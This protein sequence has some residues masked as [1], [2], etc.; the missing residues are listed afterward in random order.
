ML[1][2]FIRRLH[3]HEYQSKELMAKYGVMT[4]RFRVI[5]NAEETMNQLAAFEA[6]E[7]VIKAQV[8]AGGRGKGKFSS[9][10]K[11]GVQLTKKYG[12]H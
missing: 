1:R 11:G 12:F 4:Q 7:F 10:L 3:L 2:Q 5:D 9:G 8:F 6:D